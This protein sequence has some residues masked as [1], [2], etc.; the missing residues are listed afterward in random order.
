MCIPNLELCISMILGVHPICRL[1]GKLQVLESPANCCISG[2]WNCYKVLPCILLMKMQIVGN[3]KRAE[4][5]VLFATRLTEY[6]NTMWIS[7]LPTK[8]INH[9]AFFIIRFKI[10]KSMVSNK[11]Q[12]TTNNHHFRS[13]QM[14]R[15]NCP[16]KFLSYT[17]V[18]VL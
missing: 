12:L 5:T 13:D 17:V 18:F 9:L 1:A 7:N 11:N 14:T 4:L 16:Y 8:N 6:K 2:G 10:L 3:Y 15:S